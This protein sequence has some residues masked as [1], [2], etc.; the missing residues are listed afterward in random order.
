MGP[1]ELV[2]QPV[3]ALQHLGPAFLEARRKNGLQST[4][5]RLNPLAL[6]S[7]PMHYQTCASIPRLRCCP[8]S[9]PE[10]K[11]TAPLEKVTALPFP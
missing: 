10:A 1:P 11:D 3:R 5:S 6:D 7:N 8:S 2:P 4:I 9:Q